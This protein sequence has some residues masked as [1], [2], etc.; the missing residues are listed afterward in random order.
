MLLSSK[1]LHEVLTLLMRLFTYVAALMIGGAV[2]LPWMRLDGESEAHSGAELIGLLFTP[3][4]Q[5]LYAVS[6]VQTVVL[7]GCPILVVLSTFLV[8]FKYSQRKSAILATLVILA[9][10]IAIIYVTRDLADNAGDRT[11]VGLTGTISLSA[12]L[13]VHQGL[14]KLRTRLYQGRKLPIVHRVLGVVTG[15]GYYRWSES[16]TR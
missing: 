15:S 11:Y 14:I 10:C 5:Y 16:K 1:N 6:P 9:S 13:L 3:S 2:F 7:V 8:I 4:V 12:V